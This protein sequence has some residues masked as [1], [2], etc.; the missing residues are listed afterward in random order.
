[1]YCLGLFLVVNKIIVYEEIKKLL[2]AGSPIPIF[3]QSFISISYLVFEIRVSKLNNN[4]KKN[5]F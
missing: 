4:N 1:M 5:N 3:V 2:H